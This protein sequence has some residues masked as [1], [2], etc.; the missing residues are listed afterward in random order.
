MK[1]ELEISNNVIDNYYLRINDLVLKSKESVLRIVNYEMVVLYYEIGYVIN[2]LIEKYNLQALQNEIM[3]NFS[4]KLT[5]QFG[6]GFSVPT[7]KKAKK[8]YLTYKGFYTLWNQL[9]W[10]HNRLIMNIEGETKRNFYLEECIKA[11]WSVRQLEWQINSF[12]YERCSG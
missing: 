1:N 8:F 10:S 11:N 2:E 4:E 5:N 9:S 12:Y 7:L 6:Q 3:R